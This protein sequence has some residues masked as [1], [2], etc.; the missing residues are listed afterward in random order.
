MMKARPLWAV[1]AGSIAVVIV[2]C[3]SPADRVTHEN[4]T[5]QE[6]MRDE[7]DANAHA[8]W[9]VTNPAIDDQVGI[10]P[11]KMTEAR[12]AQMEKHANAMK[13]GAL[14]IARMDPPVVANPGQ[15]ISDANI[16]GGYSTA[17]VQAAVDQNP[18]GLR[19]AARS[20]AIYAALLSAAAYARDARAAGPLIDGLN[21]QCETC[22]LEFWYPSQRAQLEQTAAVSQDI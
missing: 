12:W 13:Q 19:E 6:I 3:S 8:L 11:E 18:Q 5:I 1:L 9:T 10:D 17:Q 7:V 16:E 22:H 4:L 15:D 2:A 14:A 20:F 21:S